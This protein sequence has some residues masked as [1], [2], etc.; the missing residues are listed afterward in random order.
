MRAQLLCLWSVPVFGAALVVAFLAFPGFFPPMS[1]QMTAD[2]VASFYGQHTAMIRFSMIVFNLCGI[3]LA[4][5][6]A[7]IVVQVMRM[8]TPS[9]VLAFCYLTTVVMPLAVQGSAITGA[10]DTACPDWTIARHSGAVATRRYRHSHQ[11]RQ[12][13][14]RAVS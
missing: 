11:H 3:M 6:F 13:Q 7:V 10:L 9:H 2:Q 12:G 4:P 14:S 5:F 8:R 1:P